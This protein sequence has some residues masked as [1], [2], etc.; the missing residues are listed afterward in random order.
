MTKLHIWVNDLLLLIVV[1]LILWKLSIN[2]FFMLVYAGI[3]KFFMRLVLVN[4]LL[5]SRNGV[6]EISC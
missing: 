5:I 1:V 3:V 6:T 4:S 2:L